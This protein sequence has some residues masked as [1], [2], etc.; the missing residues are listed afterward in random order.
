M[1]DQTT[2]GNIIVFFKDLGIYDV[3]LPFL[4]VFTLVFAI[5]EKTRVFGTEKIGETEYP[6]KNLNAMTAFVIA[7]LVIASSKLVALINEAAANMV[8]LI[9]VSVF[10]L[11]LASTFYKEGKFELEGGWKTFF[12]ILMFVGVVLIFSY[13]IKIDS[14][15]QYC[16]GY[17]HGKCPALAYFWNYLDDNWNSNAVGSIILIVFI[18]AFMY[19]VTKDNSPKKE[20]EKT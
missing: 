7:F 11:V 10:F 1:A 20:K 14:T 3:V 15:S 18:I 4:L 5:F 2:F 19:F 6:K 13:A 12:M 17:E 8:V 16:S 9:M